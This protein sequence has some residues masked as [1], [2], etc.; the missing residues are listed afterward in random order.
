MLNEKFKESRNE[1]NLFIEEAPFNQLIEGSIDPTLSNGDVPKY[2][3]SLVRVQELIPKIMDNFYNGEENIKEVEK[4]VEHFLEEYISNIDENKIT[5]IFFPILV[6]RYNQIGVLQKEKIRLQELHNSLNRILIQACK[7]SRY[8]IFLNTQTNPENEREWYDNVKDI[9]FSQPLNSFANERI[10]QQ[11]F[12]QIQM[13]EKKTIKL[14]VLDC[15]NTIW[16]G[17]LGEDGPES[18]EMSFGFPGEMFHVFQHQLKK[19][20]Q[21]GVMLAICSKNNE[22]EVLEMFENHKGMILKQDDITSIKA[23][24]LNKSSNIDEILRLI[25]VLPENTLF[26][27]DSKFELDEVKEHFPDI[28]TC[29]VPRNIEDLPKML[30]NINFESKSHSLTKEDQERTSMMKAEEI[31]RKELNSGTF[32]NYLESL[33]LKLEIE[34]LRHDDK[35]KVLRFHQ[36]VNKTNQFN[37]TT[38]RLD[39][40][41]IHLLLNSHRNEVYLMNAE[42]RFGN[43]GITGAVVLEKIDDSRIVVQNYLLSCRVLGRGI[44]ETFLTSLLNEFSNKG[45]KRVKIN[46][47]ES[48][49]NMPALKFA[50]KFQA[51]KEV[52]IDVF[53]QAGLKNPALNVSCEE[54]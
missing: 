22:F 23:N 41:E 44:E 5:N 54:S 53:S 12:Q 36:L 8:T 48:S 40:A 13:I 33:E 1:D 4:E 9:L 11:I 30:S 42:D 29:L 50:E 34:K 7:S 20:Q 3:V 38:I 14:I 15:D 28:Q 32:Q 51:N 17:V 31:R 21:N 2:I 6:H 26:I 35:E 47:I 52:D 27:D 39:P 49:K 19:L 16:G 25:N 18:L 46:F 10:A 43:Y 24:W 45:F 37:F